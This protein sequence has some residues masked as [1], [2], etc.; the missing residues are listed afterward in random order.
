MLLNLCRYV[1]I[2]DSQ[3]VQ[4]QNSITPSRHLGRFEDQGFWEDHLSPKEAFVFRAARAMIRLESHAQ[5]TSIPGFTIK[6]YLLENLLM[7]LVS[8]CHVA[9]SISA[10]DANTKGQGTVD[11]S[12]H[13]HS[14]HQPLP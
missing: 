4:Y 6:L 7:H 8:G 3:K 14:P 9:A 5:R 13:P 10:M 2:L 12:K 11:M 1:F